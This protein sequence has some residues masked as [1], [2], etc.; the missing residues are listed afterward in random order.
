MIMQEL[1]YP[2]FN[3]LEF[4]INL[5]NIL[6]SDL[7]NNLQHNAKKERNMRLIKTVKTASLLS[8][9]GTSIFLRARRNNIQFN[10][11]KTET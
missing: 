5:G 7:Q 9:F 6:V 10:I 1:D 4:K 3:L 11:L 2:V 8:F